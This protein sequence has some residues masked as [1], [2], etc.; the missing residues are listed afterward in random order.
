VAGETS[1]DKQ[2][3]K[4]SLGWGLILW[5]VGYI[6]GIIFF[7]VFPPALLGWFIM[8]VGIALTLWVLMK[9]VKGFNAQGYLILAIVWTIIAIVFDFFF[10]V[11]MFKP[12]DGYYKLDVYL[13]Y[14]FTFMIPLIFGWW[15]K[16]QSEE[17]DSGRY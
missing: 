11:K 5:L 9:K 7:F 13:Y 10:I 2:L 14:A 4:Y 3:L 12:T 16:T 1:M 8:P 15:K 6:L 17:V